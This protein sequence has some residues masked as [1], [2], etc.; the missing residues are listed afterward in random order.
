MGDEIQVLVVGF[1]I[2]MWGFGE[3]RIVN[4]QTCWIQNVVLNEQRPLT[5][6]SGYPF[7]LSSE[8]TPWSTPEMPGPGLSVRRWKWFPGIKSSCAINWCHTSTQFFMKLQRQE[9]P[10][11]DRSPLTTS[12]TSGCTV[13]NFSISINLGLHSRCPRWEQQGVCQGFFSGRGMV[14]F[15]CRKIRGRSLRHFIAEGSYVH[16][17]RSTISSL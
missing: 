12:M 6:P 3:V 10:C 4:S 7:P 5:L 16:S 17:R 14:L 2:P 8:A 11:S 9:C 1:A 13:C 15:V